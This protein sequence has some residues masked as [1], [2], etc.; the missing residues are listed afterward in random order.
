MPYLNMD[1]GE[2]PRFSGDVALAPN[3]HWVFVEETAPPAL[4]ERQMLTEGAPTK[5]D[6]G[7][8]RQTWIVSTLTESEWAQRRLAALKGRLAAFGLSVE[9]LKLLLAEGN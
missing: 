8:W 6:K 2:Y 1:T 9:D 3:A 7:I 4:G 5:D